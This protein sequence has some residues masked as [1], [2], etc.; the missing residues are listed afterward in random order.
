MPIIGRVCEFGFWL[1]KINSVFSNFYLNT[2]Y[3]NILPA[4]VYPP[5]P[6]VPSLLPQ[7]PLVSSFISV[8]YMCFPFL[9]SPVQ[10]LTLLFLSAHVHSGS[11]HLIFIPRNLIQFQSLFVLCSV[12]QDSVK[13]L[14]FILYVMIEWLDSKREFATLISS[15]TFRFSNTLW[16][17]FPMFPSSD[18]QQSLQSH[19]QSHLACRP[20]TTLPFWT[21]S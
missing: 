13:H 17:G 8:S 10:S 20:R 12:K 21:N 4:T 5:D 6:T 1:R 9:S 19:G 15:L 14:P 18:N 3:V 7:L 16:M 2:F 11:S